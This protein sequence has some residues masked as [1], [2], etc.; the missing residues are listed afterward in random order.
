MIVLSK[1]QKK[2]FF[3]VSMTKINDLYVEI[4][5]GLTNW[6]VNDDR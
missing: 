2:I 3:F 4:V 5:N 1:F 6:L